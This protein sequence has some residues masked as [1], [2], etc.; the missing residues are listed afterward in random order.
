MKGRFKILFAFVFWAFVLGYET[1]LAVA[2]Y[3]SYDLLH[4]WVALGG[5]TV[6]ALCLFCELRLFAR[7]RYK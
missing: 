6:L 5:V 2:M 3:N 7:R 4:S 1:C